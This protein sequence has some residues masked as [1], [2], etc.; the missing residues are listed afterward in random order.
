[1]GSTLNQLNLLA[2]DAL[3]YENYE[4]LHRAKTWCIQE[5]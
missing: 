4:L 3:H 2:T 1:M 5:D